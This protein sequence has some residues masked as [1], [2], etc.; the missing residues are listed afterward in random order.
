MAE[1][2][3]KN[4]PI[5]KISNAVALGLGAG[6]AFGGGVVNIGMMLIVILLGCFME[7]PLYPL[8]LVGILAFG[9]S[10]GSIESSSYSN[11]NNSS[12]L[13]ASI[14]IAAAALAWVA[15]S[16]VTYRLGKGMNSQFNSLMLFSL[17]IIYVALYLVLT[18]L[19]V[20][21]ISGKI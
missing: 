10:Y 20:N 7:S 4:R 18:V 15:S 8:I 11:I 9:Y 19:L 14:A 5:V 2:D 3:A 21:L 6:L 13:F 1:I 16:K 12:L 17:P